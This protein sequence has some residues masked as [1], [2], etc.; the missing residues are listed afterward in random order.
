MC[1][2]GGEGGCACREG[3][4]AIVGV[5]SRRNN[6]PCQVSQSQPSRV[7][8]WGAG[9]TASLGFKTTAQQGKALR[10]LVSDERPARPLDQRVRRAVGDGPWC[11]ALQDLL[12]ILGDNPLEPESTES[13]LAVTPCQMAAMRSNWRSGADDDELRRRIIGLRT[14]YDWPALQAAV[15]VCPGALEGS[16]FQLNDLFNLLDMHG[17][18]GHGFRKQQLDIEEERDEFLTPQE[19]VGARNALRM[20]LQ[21]MLY[22]DWQYCREE[23]REDLDRHYEFAK[24][25]G[26]RLQRHGMGLAHSSRFD[27]R[28]FY[29]G[30]VSFVS[31]NYDPVGLWCQFVA[32]RD[33]NRSAAVPHVDSPALRLQVFH[34]LGHFVAG[35]RVRVGGRDPKTPWHPMNETSAQRLNDPEHRSG[36]RIRITKFLFPHG[37]LWW[38]ECPNCGKL[39]SYM[40]QSWDRDSSALIPPPPLKAFVPDADALKPRSDEEDKAWKRGEV[41]ARAC[42]HCQTLTYAHHTQTRMQSNFK[43]AAPPFLEEIGRDLRVAVQDADHIIL[44]GYS[45]PPDDVAYRAFFAARQRRDVKVKCSVVVGHEEERRWL[46]PSEWPD[47]ASAM[48]AGM[49]PRT[50]LEAAKDLFG[51]DNVRFFGGGIPQVFL[52]GGQVTDAAVER[53]LSWE[54]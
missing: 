52:D 51:K 34:D 13:T 48:K 23:K 50:T 19:V 45:L 26:R 20:L 28:D 18:S 11:S 7:V 27:S 36:D 47:R 42:V 35:S 53:L 38:R 54:A 32:N 33:L 46:G 31:L 16:N 17:Q 9:A 6:D 39:S 14:L 24:A 29:L 37:C 15:R 4:G 43:G 3:G 41:D 12:T 40:G 22:V 1:G 2:E 21:A 30:D 49:P 8:F 44:M 25:I 5:D 10:S